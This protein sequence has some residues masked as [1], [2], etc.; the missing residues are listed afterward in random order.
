MYYTSIEE[1]V[2]TMSDE[3]YFDIMMEAFV[4]E[5]AEATEEAKLGM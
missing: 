5:M 2:A 1:Y 4:D 3:E